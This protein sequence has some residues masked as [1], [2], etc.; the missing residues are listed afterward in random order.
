MNER[1]TE[2]LEL[3]EERDQLV[4]ECEHLEE[5]KRVLRTALEQIRDLPAHPRRKRSLTIAEAALATL[6]D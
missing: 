3:E 5:Q 4:A 2:L 6:G 1:P